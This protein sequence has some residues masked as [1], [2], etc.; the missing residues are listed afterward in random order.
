MLAE[1]GVR[2]FVP[3]PV[4][5]RDDVAPAVREAVAARAPAPPAPAAAPAP[6]AAVATAVAPAAVR[7][8]SGDGVDGLGW[9]ALEQVV[10]DWASALRRKP[11]FG[12]GDRQPDWLCV[13]DPPVEEELRRGAPF[14]GD[15]GKLLD[16]M[17]QAVGASRRRGAYLTNAFKCR[18]PDDREREAEEAAR[19]ALVLQRQ[20]ELL[21]PRVILAMGRFAVQ[22]L[23]QV[24][25]PPGRLRGRVHRYGDVPVVVTFHPKYL[26]HNLPDK[27]RAWADL[28]LAQTVLR[29]DA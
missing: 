9:E 24:N 14:A 21:R 29:A 26:L 27:G 15:E 12:E 23:L 2:V 22:M 6:L 18:L 4:P 20:V 13:G 3:E 19:W 25:E 1:M 5:G 7:I 17:L 8:P 16:N 28:C 10:G 11:V